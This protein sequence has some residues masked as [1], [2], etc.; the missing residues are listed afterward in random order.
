MAGTCDPCGE[1]S[2]KPALAEMIA[3]TEKIVGSL[4]PYQLDIIER[5]WRGESYFYASP[6]GLRSS[7][8]GQVA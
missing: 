1:Q 2:A 8:D 5:A 4:S 3:A 6:R 7:A